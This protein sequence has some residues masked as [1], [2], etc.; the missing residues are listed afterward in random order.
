MSTAVAVTR[1]SAPPIYGRQTRLALEK[2][3]RWHA[4]GSG[5][6]GVR[7][8]LRAGQGGRRPGQHGAGCPRFRTGAAIVA[9]ATGS[10]R[11]TIRISSRSRSCTVG[12][13][14]RPT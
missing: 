13:V 2:L 5:S 8:R 14:P 1:E 3:P 10:P 4:A 7:P 12:A 11:G 9:A 6:A